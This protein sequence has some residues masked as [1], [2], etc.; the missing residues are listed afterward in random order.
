[1][2]DEYKV[3]AFMSGLDQRAWS[4]DD[5]DIAFAA[6]QQK[7]CDLG[8]LMIVALRK[9]AQQDAEPFKIPKEQTK[10][11]TLEKFNIGGN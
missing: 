3:K 5:I 1:M 7:M 11:E 9:A 8:N 4:E 6:H 10:E 2:T